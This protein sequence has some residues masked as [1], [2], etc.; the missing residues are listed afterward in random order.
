MNSTVTGEYDTGGLVGLNHGSI[1]DSAFTGAVTGT[2]EVEY[3]DWTGGL[4]GYNYGTITRCWAGAT[5]VSAGDIVGGLVGE[6]LTEGIITESYSAG[7]VTADDYTGGLVGSNSGEI[8]ACYSICTVN[9]DS[10]VGGLIGGNS[11]SI[12]DSFA[13]GAVAGTNRIGGLA[14]SSTGATVTGCYWDTE[15]SGQS[16]SASGTGK[17]TAEMKQRTT[18]ENWDFVAIWDINAGL[19]AGYPF[20]RWKVTAT[21]WEV[22]N[23]TQLEAALNGFQSGDTIKLTAD[24]TYNKGIVIDGK[25][26]TFDTGSCTQCIQLHRLLARSWP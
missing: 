16:T 24:F 3:G 9:G 6:N 19:N 17:I 14:G 22:A 21:V 23:A 7:D 4:V 5:V 8:T 12:A 25:D 20:L 11:G 15:A 13:A 18:F 10:N 2:Y 26:L 1:T